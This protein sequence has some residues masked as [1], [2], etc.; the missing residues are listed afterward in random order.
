MNR[1]TPYT[2]FFRAVRWTV[3]HF[4]GTCER[5]E[6]PLPSPCVVVCRHKNGSGPIR[7]LLMMEEEVRPWVL[8]V[9][10]EKEACR[11]HFRR[12]TLPMR[13][14][15]PPWLAAP[16]A[17]AVSW[18]VPPL[19]RAIGG[20][21]VHRGSARALSTLRQTLSALERGQRVI[22]YPD[23]NY[24]DTAQEVK[25]LYGGYLLL[26]RLFAQRCGGRL[27]FVPAAAVKGA[28]MIG[29]PLY[30]DEGEPREAMDERMR[31]ALGGLERGA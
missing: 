24:A 9:F 10:C 31:R 17:L 1:Q 8:D 13:L 16:C 4:C 19:M 2:V 5:R 15:M 14:H 11:R 21:P 7:T 26:A 27:A 20:I 23:V 12:F 22:I 28:I 18:V 3:R 6:A 29:A 25:A 30:A